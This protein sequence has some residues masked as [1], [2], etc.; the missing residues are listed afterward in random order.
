LYFG[1]RGGWL[2]SAALLYAP[3]F[4]VDL[5]VRS[6]MAEFAA[7]PF[8]VLALYGFGA[9]A[10]FG[11]RGHL[12]VG[13]AAF[14]GVI[15]SHNAASLMF[16]PLL[17]A[18]IAFTAWSEGRGRIL[19]W[20][21]AGFAIG[22]GLGAALW[23]PG[24]AERSDIHID[25]VLQGYLHYSNHFVYFEQLFYSPWGF[26]MSVAGLKD[27]MAFTLGWGH[28]PLV[29]L[30]VALAA[31]NRYW[32][33]FF[34]AAAAIFCFLMLPEAG[35]IWKHLPLLQYL[36]FPWRL[37]GPAA[38]CLAL[39]IAPLGSVL[40]GWSRWRTPAF[41]VAMGLLILPNLSHMTARG[42]RDV[43]PAF[44]TPHFIAARGVDVTTAGEYVPRW[45][46]TT[47]PYSAR[48]ASLMEGDADIHETARSPVSWAAQVTARMPSSIQIATSYFPGWQVRVDGNL[49]ETTPSRGTGQIRFNVPQGAHHVES[50]WSRTG[51]VWLG[52]G[53]SLLA[54]AGLLLLRWA[55]GFGNNSKG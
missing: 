24:M 23:L 15:L 48:K 14:A 39:F 10:K 29:L 55:R 30:A 13:T 28:M 46:E 31:R 44:W 11:K 27:G 47:A 34:G 4:S 8:A 37:L 25:R 32:L 22:L 1:A 52:D 12:M 40:D 41:T 7:F 20:Q 21:A 33:G 18:F 54:L 35:W 26:G 38:I 45:V 51:A 3:Y 53:I 50:Y 2:A 16:T 9:F 36:E 6:A 43:D 17:I 49:V 19:V 42:V 5:F